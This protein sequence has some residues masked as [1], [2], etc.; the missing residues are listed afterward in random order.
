MSI[1]AQSDA[2]GRPRPVQIWLA[3]W[4]AALFA[5]ALAATDVRVCPCDEIVDRHVALFEVLEP[6]EEDAGALVAAGE[7]ETGDL[8]H[9]V[10]GRRLPQFRADAAIRQVPL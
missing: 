10:N 9:R 6:D 8:E 2:T 5:V 4:A 7:A 3:I 1:A